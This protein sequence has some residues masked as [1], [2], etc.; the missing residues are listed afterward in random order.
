V[1][2]PSLA[3]LPWR[4]F[5]DDTEQTPSDA[6]RF[7]WH[8]VRNWTDARLRGLPAGPR[9]LAYNLNSW[10]ATTVRSTTAE[11]GRYVP[12]AIQAGY[13][14]AIGSTGEPVTTNAPYVDT[15]LAG[16]MSGWT[17]GECFY[18][19]NPYDDLTWTLVGDPLLRVPDWSPPPTYVAADFDVDGDV[20][21]ADFT[22]LQQ[23]FTGPTPTVPLCCVPV[24]L[25]CDD[26]VDLNDFARLQTCFNGPNQPP[27]CAR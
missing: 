5:D 3:W 13:A 4:A 14:A 23:C 19:S 8:D 12:N 20:D 21:M 26:D 2:C 25:D 17:L 15:L 22:M 11:E 27:R 16:L 6:F 10:G 9:I 1:E 7:G 18:L 24:D